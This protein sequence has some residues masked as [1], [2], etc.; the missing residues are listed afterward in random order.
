MHEL[1]GWYGHVTS[2]NNYAAIRGTNA[3][4]DA[5]R[6]REEWLPPRPIRAGFFM[7][8]ARGTER[9]QPIGLLNAQG[10]SKQLFSRNGRHTQQR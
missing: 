10:V 4:R 5:N 3:A 2:E 7:A 6:L 9:A 8:A 1:A